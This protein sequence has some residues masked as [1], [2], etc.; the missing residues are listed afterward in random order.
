[1]SKEKIYRIS[2]SVTNQYMKQPLISTIDIK[3][4]KERKEVDFEK[5]IK[6]YIAM[7]NKKNLEF[8]SIIMTETLKG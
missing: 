7:T 8:R 4:K 5:V 3:T 6:K 2:Y 1:M